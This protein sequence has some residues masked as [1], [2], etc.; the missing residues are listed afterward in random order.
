MTDRAEERARKIRLRL[1]GGEDLPEVVISGQR[2]SRLQIDEIL[3]AEFRSVEEEA[4][5]E[6]HEGGVLY[7]TIRAERN[8][9]VA[10]VL[11]EEVHD[12]RDRALALKRL[13]L[14]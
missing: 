12:V 7:R 6:A 9:E 11:R 10:L 4:F 14:V 3:A 13:G 5:Q 1:C 2:W 8:A